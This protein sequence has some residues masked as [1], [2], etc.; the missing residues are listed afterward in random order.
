[1]TGWGCDNWITYKGR[2]DKEKAQGD[3]E[4]KYC[5]RSPLQS[6]EQEQREVNNKE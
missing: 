2:K 1:V 6:G 5:M 4:R 3:G